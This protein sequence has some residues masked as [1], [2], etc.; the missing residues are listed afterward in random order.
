MEEWN[1]DMPECTW[2]ACESSCCDLKEYLVYDPDNPLTGEKD[3]PSIFQWVQLNYTIEWPKKSFR[4]T[5]HIE[6]PELEAIKEE[7]NVET[8]AVLDFINR[9]TWAV[10]FK[11]IAG[12]SECLTKEWCVLGEKRPLAC[13][14]FPFSFHPEYPI[15]ESCPQFLNIA[16]NERYLIAVLS[17]RK[18]AW[19]TDNIYYFANFEEILR[20]NGI[21]KSRK[22]LQDPEMVSKCL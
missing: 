7:V 22:F 10:L 21:R 15:A 12:I 16:Q 6:G 18:K 11:K 17:M 5:T 20:K 8:C 3:K 4:T 9:D 1:G 2:E 14:I 13:K 19:F